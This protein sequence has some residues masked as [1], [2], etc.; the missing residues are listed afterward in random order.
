M[1][2]TLPKFQPSSIMG[3]WSTGENKTIIHMIW[4]FFSEPKSETFTPW[5]C[6]T[7]RLKIWHR[8]LLCQ[9][10]RYR[11]LELFCMKFE[12]HTMPK[13]INHMKNFNS[14]NADMSSTYLTTKTRVRT[15][16]LW[17][18]TLLCLKITLL[19][20]Q[21]SSSIISYS[22]VA[23]CMCFPKKIFHLIWLFYFRR[24]TNFP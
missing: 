8:I 21:C 2:N 12:C 22:K 5:F 20:F 6:D 15:L 3:S 9:V 19:K 23:R 18:S 16:K 24:L 13:H 7:S 14:R 4:I 10:C 17:L 11:K 1:R